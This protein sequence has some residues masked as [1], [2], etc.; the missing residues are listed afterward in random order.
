MLLFIV[1]AGITNVS[2]MAK[3][4]LNHREEAVAARVSE[5]QHAQRAKGPAAPQAMVIVAGDDE[6]WGFGVL[7]L[8]NPINRDLS[9][10]LAI[11]LGT[12]ETPLWR[13]DLSAKILAKW[14]EG[15]DVWVTRRVRAM[16][17][18]SGWNWT[19]GD[20]PL[21]SWKDINVFFAELEMGQPVGGEDGFMLLLPTPKNEHALQLKVRSVASTSV[22]APVPEPA[23]LD[24]FVVVKMREGHSSPNLVH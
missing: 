19:E 17:P 20:D 14:R 24:H 22:A 23:K 4:V 1:A 7:F 3:P 12:T 8:L 2:V 15:G 18:R 9:F 11:T 6:L 21:V 10:E 5:L 16:R 13:K